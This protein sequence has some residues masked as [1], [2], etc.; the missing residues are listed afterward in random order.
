MGMAVKHNHLSQHELSSDDWQILGELEL[1]VGFETSGRIGSWLAETLLPLKLHADFYDK[2]SKS[3]HEAIA[4]LLLP[5]RAGV[6]FE[7]LHLL[8]FVPADS[9]LYR[10]NWGFFRIE[11]VASATT[12]ESIPDHVIELFLYREE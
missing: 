5:S 6:P 8:I 1:P 4:R 7:H 2:V 12:E 3:V 11:K 10:Q 9:S